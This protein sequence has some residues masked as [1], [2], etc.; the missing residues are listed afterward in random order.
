[1]DGGKR[2]LTPA[3]VAERYENRVTVRTLANWRSAGVSP[4][5]TKVGGRILYRLSDLVD[6]EAK[7]TVSG[8][9]A[10]RK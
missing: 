3:E 9:A 7:R 6:W 4:P 2:F 10:Y 1:M 8:T 5:F